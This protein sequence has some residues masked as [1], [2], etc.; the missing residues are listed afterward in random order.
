MRNRLVHLA[1]VCAVLGAGPVYS[2]CQQSETNPNNVVA[3]LAQAPKRYYKLDFVLKESNEG[4]VVNQRLF[5]MSVSAD[6]AGSH[7]H[8]WWNLRAGTRLPVRD[9]NGTNFVDVGVNLD[10]A[11]RDADNGLQLDVTTEISS[12]ATE[13]TAGPPPIRQVKVKAAVFSPVGKPTTVFTAEDPVSRHQ[14]EL[15]VTPTREK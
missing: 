1:V 4:K 11:A 8:S 2:L 7:E 6:P 13:E 5:N 3:A 12:V 15:E 10:V 9:P 14:F